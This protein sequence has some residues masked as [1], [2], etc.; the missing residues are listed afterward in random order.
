M[1]AVATMVVCFGLPPDYFPCHGGARD[2]DG[3]ARWIVAETKARCEQEHID[4]IKAEMA[5]EGL[6]PTKIFVQCARA[7]G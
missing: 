5:N 4:W 2:P 3:A 6:I 7:G 1:W